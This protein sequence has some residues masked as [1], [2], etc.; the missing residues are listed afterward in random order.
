MD[1]DVSSLMVGGATTV[2]PMAIFV[3]L[4]CVLGTVRNPNRWAVVSLLIFVFVVPSAQ[5]FVLLGLDFSFIRI[6]VLL[7]LFKAYVS[8]SPNGYRFSAPDRYIFLWAAWS[9]LAYAILLGSVSAFL[10]RAGFMVDAVGAY[11]VGRIYVR[12][13]ADL[14]RVVLFVGYASIPVM[15]VFLFERA[16]GR[17]MFHVFGGIDQ[18]TLI[19]EGRLR[20]QG[21]FSHPIMAGLFWASFL[22]W[23][24][25]LWVRRDASRVLVLAMT[26][27]VTAVIVNTASSTPVMGVLLVAFGLGMYSLRRLLPALRWTAILILFAAQVIMDKG[28][29]HLI[30]RVNVFA[31]ST[32]WHRY[33]LI[34]QA[35]NH[36]GEWALVGTKSTDHWGDGLGDVTNQFILEAV[37]GGLL[38]M[39]LFALFLASSFRLV[40]KAIDISSS[41]LDRW[42]PWT[43]GVVLFVHFFSF[44]S[45]SY[46]GQLVAS[47]FLFSGVIVSISA[48]AISMHDDAS[49]PRR[50]AK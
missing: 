50:L 2:H 45:V 13:W 20:C 44:L 16:T 32:G 19:R 35:M 49:L 42:I 48:Q 39:M 40:G 21:P 11:F 28:A 15:G 12:S 14:R 24:A 43:G 36:F 17:N 22:P 1:A 4:L 5:R 38:G 10:T 33:H 31:G 6:I 26:G 9:A 34:D 47:F 23:L 3:L 8:G 18:Y 25:L 7:A 41:D 46:F 27:A 30:A 29:A 37:R